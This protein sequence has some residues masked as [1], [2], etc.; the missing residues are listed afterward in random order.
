LASPNRCLGPSRTSWPAQLQ[1]SD[2]TAHAYT[3]RFHVEYQRGLFLP[4]GGTCNLDKL[5]RDAKAD[6]LFLNLMQRFADQGR[7]ISD[8]PNSPN[9]A[10]NALA[11]DPEAKRQHIRRAT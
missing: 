3:C 9:Y 10:P 11:D 6:E 8:K 4:E 5:A 7:N 1:C 2:A